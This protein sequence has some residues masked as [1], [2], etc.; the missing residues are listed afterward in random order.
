[1]EGELHPIKTCNSCQ[2]EIAESYKFCNI[3]GEIQLQ[4]C[5]V[6]YHSKWLS[7]KQV[8]LFFVTQ[9][10]ICLLPLAVEQ[11]D[12]ESSLLLD[13]LSAI[14][15]LIFFGYNWRENC[16]V[17]SWPSFSLKK[18][19]FYSF[20]AILASLAV[21]YIVGKLN[22]VIFQK[23]QSYYDTFEYH[24]YG[25]YLMVLSIAIF[26]AVFEELAFRGFVLQKL[27]KVV[28]RQQ[29][30]YITSVLFFIIHF[31]LIS[32]FWLLPFALV[33]GFIRLRENTIWYSIIIHFLF[34]LTACLNEV[35]NV[36]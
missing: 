30:V 12:I 23:E 15:C 33:L 20:I 28:D 6:E 27:L 32:V 29:A 16:K 21:Q 2:S 10:V 34:N 17:L 14:V 31:S 18:V 19:V 22:V 25:K 24:P 26:P 8:A 11:D 9:I 4:T 5:K 35:Y 7:L 3:C 36:F 13:T 1:M